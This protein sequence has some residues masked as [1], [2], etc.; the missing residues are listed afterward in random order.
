MLVDGHAGVGQQRPRLLDRQRQITRLLGHPIRLH[1][2][3][4]GYQSAQQGHRL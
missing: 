4:L 2:D 3:E 1:L